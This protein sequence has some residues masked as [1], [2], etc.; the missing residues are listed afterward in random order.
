M[1]QVPACS[2]SSSS[3]SNGGSHVD[4]PATSGWICLHILGGWQVCCQWAACLLYNARQVVTQVMP[5]PSVISWNWCYCST[6]LQRVIDS[7]ARQGSNIFWV[8]LEQLV[9]DAHTMAL[10]V[11]QS[12]CGSST[13][14]GQT[15][16]MSMCAEHSENDEVHTL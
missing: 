2:S 3:S 16:H 14:E 8:P 5:V 6:F 11:H 4:N 15:R 1:Y 13:N 7:Q 10:L 12:L 9:M